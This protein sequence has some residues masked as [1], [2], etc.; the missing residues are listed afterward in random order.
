MS[1]TGLI[2]IV[3]RRDQDVDG[4]AQM[5]PGAIEFSCDVCDDAVMVSQQG[6]AAMQGQEDVRMVCLQCIDQYPPPGLVDDISSVPGAAHALAEASGIPA[7]V[8][9]RQ[10]REQIA[11]LREW[12]RHHGQ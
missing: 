11:H 8:W 1:G 5:M 10:I 12:R 3:M 6:M 7:E 9:D 2:L 4:W